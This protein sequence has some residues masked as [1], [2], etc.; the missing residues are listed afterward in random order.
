[1]EYDRYDSEL[2][3][4]SVVKSDEAI[5]V[6]SGSN[7]V[8]VTAFETKLYVHCKIMVKSCTQNNFIKFLSIVVW[9]WYNYYLYKG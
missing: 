7:D 2:R 5:Y 3:I 4:K 6:C 1:V 9:V 8:D